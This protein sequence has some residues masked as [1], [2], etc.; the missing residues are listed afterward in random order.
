MRKLIKNERG[1]ATYI[2]VIIFTLI[3]MLTITV[4]SSI[5]SVVQ[6]KG[7]IDVAVDQIVRQIQLS[8]KVDS[9]TDDMKA[10]FM[11][12]FNCDDVEFEIDSQFITRDGCVTC[13]QLGTPFYFKVKA[14]MHLGG[15]WKFAKFP[16]TMTTQSAGVSE[17]YWK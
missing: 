14:T 5:L 16:L 13:I 15:F 9:N 6:T 8:G 3:A 17:H 12:T 7:K 2:S 1:D 10:Y 4:M 11:Q